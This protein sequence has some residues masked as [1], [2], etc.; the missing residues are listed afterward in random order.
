MDTA[1]R[2]HLARIDDSPLAM[3]APGEVA[4]ADSASALFLPAATISGCGIPCFSS[5]ILQRQPLYG[6]G[7]RPCHKSSRLARPL[8][9]IVGKDRAAELIAR[10]IDA[11]IPRREN[12]FSV[13]S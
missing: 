5:R 3:P 6:V 9:L 10:D 11:A 13:G 4:H 1:V 2:S 12:A 7:I 8:V